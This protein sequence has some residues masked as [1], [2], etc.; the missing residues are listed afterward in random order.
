MDFKV[1]IILLNGPDAQ[2]FKVTGYI[3][4][5]YAKQ[6]GYTRKPLKYFAS[7]VH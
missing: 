6:T 4:A 2:S 7:R 5:I 1:F 3:C